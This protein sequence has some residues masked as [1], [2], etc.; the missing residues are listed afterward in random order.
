MEKDQRPILLASR[1]MHN[2]PSFSWKC[3]DVLRAH[4]SSKMHQRVAEKKEYLP[5]VPKLCLQHGHRCLHKMQTIFTAKA[6]A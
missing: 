5:N 3:C 4:L 2:L 6:F 1:G